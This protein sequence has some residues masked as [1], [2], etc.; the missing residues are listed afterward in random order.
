MRPRRF[1][2]RSSRGT[3]L[4]VALCF[5]AVIAI[6]LASYL[7]VARE[8][9]RMS[10]RS[11]Q[12]DLSKQ[13]A[14]AGLEVALAAVNNNDWTGW[15]L[16][17]TTAT[18]TVTFASNK[19]GSVGLTGSIKLRVDN[20]DAYNLSSTW[21]SGASYVIDDLIGYNG[22]WYRCLK[23]HT[24]DS[25]NQPPNLNFW[26]PE[27]LP[28]KWVA[29]TAYRVEDMVNVGGTWYRCIAAHTSGATFAVGSN[30]EPIYGV[31]LNAPPWPYVPSGQKAYVRNSTSWAELTYET[32]GGSAPIA[33]RWRVGQSYAFNDAVCYDN[34]WYRCISAH[35]SN[36]W[37]DDITNTSRWSRVD[38]LWAWSSTTAY[39]RG[40][41]VYR[42]GSWYR[43]IRAHTNQQPPNAAYWA[44]TPLGSNEWTSGKTYPVNSVV[45]FNGTWYRNTSSTSASPPNSPWVG[46]ADSPWS[47]ATTYAVNDYA[48]YGGVWY[49]C[50]AA[51]TN[52]TPNNSTYWTAVGAQVVLSEGISASADGPDA[53]T[54]L[55][56]RITPA[57]AFPNAIA[58]RQTLN[59]ASSGSV[60]SYLGAGV[61][62]YNQ[63]TAPYSGGSP[64]L[65]YSAVVA[66]GSTSSTAVTMS[67]AMT[68]SGYVAAPPQATTPFQPRFTY[69]GSTV[70]K[71]TSATPS[72]SVDPSRLSRSPY[73][74]NYSVV[75][76]PSGQQLVLNTGLG[77]STTIGVP[78]ATV[79]SY[80]Y[81]NGNLDIQNSTSTCQTL[82][83]IG[84]V[85]LTVSNGLLT[86]TN[87]RI[88]IH[89]SGSAVIRF[90][91]SGGQLF[92]GDSGSGTPLAGIENL[93]LDPRKCQLVSTSTYNSSSYHYFWQ[94]RD[95]YGILYMPS[96]YVH[97]WNNGYSPNFYGAV[98]ASNVYFN[99][100]TNLHYDT[101]L[102][103]ASFD[104]VVNPYH[105]LEYRELA[106]SE[107]ATLP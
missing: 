22:T 94:R 3:V 28:W 66:G 48:G 56:A 35:T 37:P 95:F 46:A 50:I 73:I 58:G 83:I 65:G 104:W 101:S 67:G 16:S 51:H 15:T 75:T 63:T 43:C 64:N 2:L 82:N 55:R 26:A 81:Y 39:G 34:V 71:G 93:T 5:V 36:W 86:R 62:T 17:G 54:Q 60:D 38:S 74:P 76:Q 42:S 91:S 107:R 52:Q 45:R 90:G 29:N 6:S 49:R 100:T 89:A 23:A 88:I 59:F 106:S 98:S 1:Q 103:H 24:A 33:W 105:I 97:Y 87:G 80:Y 4:L 92:I 85:V 12:T 79:P 14:E 44:D 96:A 70:V 8:A 78:G 21:T 53:R 47:S 13:L 102:R 25:S 9:M 69:A 61:Y 57:P 68:V 11:F 84:P 19:Y 72:P 77:S 20:Y 18:R 41:V 40:A 31:Y 99:H 32:W 27:G 7:A 10:H 30:W